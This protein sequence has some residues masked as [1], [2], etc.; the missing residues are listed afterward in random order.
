MTFPP[1][2]YTRRPF[3]PAARARAVAP[4]LRGVPKA[5][6]PTAIAAE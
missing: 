6:D 2:A 4:L 3:G 1:A 5:A